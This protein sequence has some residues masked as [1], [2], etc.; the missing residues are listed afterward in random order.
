MQQINNLA[1]EANELRSKAYYLEQEAS[2][3]INKK[4]LLIDS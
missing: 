3:L 2:Q 1:L 4:V